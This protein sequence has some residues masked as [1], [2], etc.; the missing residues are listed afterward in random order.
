MKTAENVAKKEKIDADA[1]QMKKAATGMAK[2]F[3]KQQQNK[4]AN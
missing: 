2:D 3:W 1:K 4:P